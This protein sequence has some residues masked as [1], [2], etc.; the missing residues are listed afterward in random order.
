MSS[1]ASIAALRDAGRGHLREKQDRFVFHDL[2]QC[3]QKLEV[4]HVMS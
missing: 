1:S 3:A 4:D 2:R